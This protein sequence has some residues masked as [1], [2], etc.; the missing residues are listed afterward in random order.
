MLHKRQ[1]D[2]ETLSLKGR[3]DTLRSFETADMTTF[4]IQGGWGG[5]KITPT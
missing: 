3:L 4:S 5:Y 1:L 2:V